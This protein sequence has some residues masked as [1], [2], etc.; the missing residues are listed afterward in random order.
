MPRD[1][2]LFP[3]HFTYSPSPLPVLAGGVCCCFR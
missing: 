3:C 1:D 2:S